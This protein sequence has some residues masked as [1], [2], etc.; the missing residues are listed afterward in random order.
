VNTQLDKTQ[1]EY[2]TMW[3]VPLTLT[4]IES[5]GIELLG[6]FGIDDA[7]HAELLTMPN[8]VRLTF[9]VY[10]DAELTCTEVIDIESYDAHILTLTPGWNS[11]S[12]RYLHAAGHKERHAYHRNEARMWQLL[13]TKVP[14]FQDMLDTER[15]DFERAIEEMTP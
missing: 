5:H 11:A 1:T 13:A 7:E 12:R 14:H 8:I 4:E 10:C 6:A 15:A 9:G 3:H 2:S